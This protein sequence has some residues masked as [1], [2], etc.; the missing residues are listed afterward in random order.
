MSQVATH[1]SALTNQGNYRGGKLHC[2]LKQELDDLE[3]VIKENWETGFERVL[4][5]E[6]ET[7]YG[8]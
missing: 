5:K 1:K 2:E 6:I 3:E 7:E 4:M 8:V